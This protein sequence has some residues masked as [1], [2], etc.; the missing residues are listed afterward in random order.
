MVGNPTISIGHR[1]EAEV[2]RPTNKHAVKSNNLFFCIQPTPAEAGPLADLATDRLDLL[3]RRT[4]AKI[5][6]ARLRVAETEGVTKKVE[7]FIG[8]A[9]EDASC[10]R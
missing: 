4:L 3:L 5:A 8:G 10:L 7:R 2:V 9:G 1:S 6:P